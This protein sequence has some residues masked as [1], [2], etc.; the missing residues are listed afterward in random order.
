MSV[1]TVISNV[2]RRGLLLAM[3]VLPACLWAQ[4]PPPSEDA[5]ATEVVGALEAALIDSMR[6]GPGMGLEQRRQKLAPVIERTLDFS[7]MARFIFGANWR[8][9]GHAD[10]ERFIQTFTDL[11]ITTYA[12]RFDKHKGE[13]FDP[14]SEAGQGQDRMLVRRRLTKGNK[15]TVSFDY[16]LM[17]VDGRWAIVNIIVDGISDLALKRSQYGLLYGKGGMDAVIENIQTQIKRLRD[18]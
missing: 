14:V 10:Q 11:S 18:E 8:Q 13:R 17:R 4:A 1:G 7:R 16:L 3:L 6:S 12:S 9:I 2:A 5:S 15:E